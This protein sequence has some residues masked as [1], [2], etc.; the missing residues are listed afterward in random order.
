MTPR[1]SSESRTSLRKAGARVAKRRRAAAA[2]FLVALSVGLCGP[3]GAQEPAGEAGRA[4]GGSAGGPTGGLT[5][6]QAGAGS[7][8][9]LPGLYVRELSIQ[10]DGRAPAVQE[11]ELRLALEAWWRE[12]CAGRLRL[13]VEGEETSR[14]AVLVSVREGTSGFLVQVSYLSED[15]RRVDSSSRVYSLSIQSLVPALAA[16]ILAL[17]AQVRGFPPVELPSPRLAGLLDLS[18]LAALD[19]GPGPESEPLDCA[20]GP[21][22]PILLFSDRTLGLGRRFELIPESARDL[23]RRP[24]LPEGFIPSHVAADAWGEALVYGEGDLFRYEP[25]AVAPR[26]T[27][28]AELGAQDFASLGGG[29]CAVL[30]SGR[31]AVGTRRDGEMRWTEVRLPSPFYT[32]I[33]GDPGGPLWLFDLAERKIRLI[34]ISEDGSLRELSS[35]KPLLS[36]EELSLPQLM[37]VF[38]GGGFVLGGSGKLWRFDSAGWPL[39][40]L[41]QFGAG[42][43]QSLPAFYRIAVDSAR[44]F[45]LLDP[46]S[47]RLLRFVDLQD[48]PAESGADGEAADG[49]GRLALRFAEPPEAADLELAGLFRRWS[50]IPALQSTGDRNSQERARLDLLETCLDRGLLLMARS[51]LPAAGSRETPMDAQAFSRALRE[52]QARMLDELGRRYEEQLLLPGAE[53]AYNDSLRI[54]RAL[55]ASDPVNEDYP[56]QVRELERRRND[57]R[58]ILLQEPALELLPP[59]LSGAEAEGGGSSLALQLRNVSGQPLQDLRFRVRVSGLPVGTLSAEIQRLAAQGTASLHADLPALASSIGA[60]VREDL[61]TRVLALV[62]VTAASGERTFWLEAPIVLRAALKP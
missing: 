40:R 14:P 35:V 59:V 58:G 31:L 44:A 41:E 53:E 5:S 60:P 34:T 49:A 21:L 45:Y 57:V 22:G 24:L 55:R 20:A 19:G 50:E 26:R 46:L 38:P 62:T 16:E 18:V 33:A 56:A 10:G 27:P 2:A 48:G 36:P 8:D 6:G 37:R 3:A 54:L 25:G 43:R 61:P 7:A 13:L 30:A 17:W 9:E 51:L 12:H 32:S 15:G 29:G 47:G 52:K 42:V 4:D 23:A 1:L 39:W 28:I 11:G